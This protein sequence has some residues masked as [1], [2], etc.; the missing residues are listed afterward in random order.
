[1]KKYILKMILGSSAILGIAPIASAC[2]QPSA[3]EKD[4]EEKYQQAV[5]DINTVSK[6][7]S[8]SIKTDVNIKVTFPSEITFNN[9]DINGVN[10]NNYQIL[11]S[12]KFKGVSLGL[13]ANND[14]GKLTITVAILSKKYSDLGILAMR[15]LSGF[16]KTGDVILPPTP[17]PVPT[18]QPE[19]KPQPE[20]VKPEPVEPKPQPEPV[21][22]EP[23]PEP[24]PVPPVMPPF[25]IP[26]FNPN[27]GIIQ[28]NSYPDYVSK[29]KA[30]NAET[31]YKEIW[32]R[33]FSIRPASL[34]TTSQGKKLVESQG[35]GWVL[36]Y[37]KVDENKYK[38]FIATNLHVI[39]NYSNTNASNIDKELNYNDPTGNQPG[40]FAIGKSSMPTSFASIGN[41]TWNQH[42]AQIGGYV[43]YY[44]NNQTLTTPDYSSLSNTQYSSS[45]SNPKVLFAAVDYMDDATYNQYADQIN[46]KWDAYKKEKQSQMQKMSMDEDARKLYEN[47]INQNP[48]KIPFYTD[49]GILEMDVDLSKADSILAD[50]IK[51]AV[52]AVDSY[53]ARMKANIPYPNYDANTATY[54]PT[55]DYLSKGRDLSQSNPVYNFGLSNAKNVYIA[56]YPKNNTNLSYWMQNNPL[57]RDS[58]QVLLQY[59]RRT[60]VA[61]GIANNKLFDYA[62]N[63][64]ESPIE[65][66]NIQIYSELW[67]RPY[68]SFYGFNYNIKFSSLYYG[69]SGSIVYNDFGEIIGIYNGVD[70]SVQFGDNISFG[71]FAPLLQTADIPVANN[72]FIYGYNL[73]DNTGYTHQTR[74][75]RSNLKLFYPNG[76]DEK[77]NK[78]TALFPEGF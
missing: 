11:Q 52:A 57:E 36:D 19:P 25:V 74:S 42:I 28:A 51:Q 75:Y 29:Y 48:S 73:I 3:I 53:V 68:A 27:A 58:D 4:K 30:V 32:D 20:P 38:L 62:T 45:L 66:G 10:T 1:M 43:K 24:G 40:G 59:N 77:G 5:A 8:V 23:Q 72:K 9:L 70:A 46:Q 41:N 61:N 14:M 63:D 33:T 12:G 22:P 64:A 78:A 35:T 76:F 65:T 39:G 26:P 67:N 16:R 6:M 44:A 47:F 31:I 37:H 7:L 21:K 49:F 71:T 54:L 15:E 17:E 34:V 18:P 69:A 2:N 50:W 13:A 55:L 60:G 56:G